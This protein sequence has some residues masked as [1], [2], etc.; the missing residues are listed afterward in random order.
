M[1]KISN[2]GIRC[3]LYCRLGTP[4][5]K[6]VW[7]YCRIAQPSAL[8][9]EAQ[10]E[11]LYSFAANH[12]FEVVGITAETG[13]G[14]TLHRRGLNRVT[15]AL[16]RG[17]ADALLVSELSRVG[18]NTAEVDTYLEWLKHRNIDLI[19]ADGAKPRTHMEYFRSL[20]EMY[21]NERP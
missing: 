20:L 4:P 3:A 1:N 19:C 17:K 9:L 18:R 8:E 6:R 16:E 11:L 13:S 10:K 12:G 15:Q 21:R 7:L 2:I 5:P 14:L